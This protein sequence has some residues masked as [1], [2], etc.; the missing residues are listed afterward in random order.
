MAV[1]ERPG[2]AVEVL[3]P[4]I[5]LW[6]AE[7]VRYHVCTHDKAL[8]VGRVSHVMCTTGHVA[9]ILVT[10]G[11]V[12][13]CLDIVGAFSTSATSLLDCVDCC[14]LVGSGALST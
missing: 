6:A 3:P 7:N 8:V 4:L 10:I 13:G 12:L 5:K 11:Q 9:Q 2:A 1:G 14:L